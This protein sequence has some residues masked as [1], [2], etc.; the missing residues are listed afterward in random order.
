MFTYKLRGAYF[1]GSNVLSLTSSLYL[2]AK[3]S[4]DVWYLPKGIVGS[5]FSKSY[6]IW[7]S[8][9]SSGFVEIRLEPDGQVVFNYAETSQVTVPAAYSID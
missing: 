1:N 8:S 4:I 7:T 9:A 3:I 5:L 2:H 6:D